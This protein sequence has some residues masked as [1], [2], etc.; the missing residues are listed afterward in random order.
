MNRIHRLVQK[1]RN[2]V[3]MARFVGPL[4][5]YIHERIGANKGGFLLDVKVSIDDKAFFLLYQ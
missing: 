1:V 3:S 4:Q 2:F 5:R